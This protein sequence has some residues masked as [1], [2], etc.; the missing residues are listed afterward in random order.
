M[1]DAPRL[2]FGPP[3]MKKPKPD[4]LIATAG[5]DP[6]ANHG[7]IN[8]P[9]YHASTVV[10][11][12]VAALHASQKQRDPKKTR[13]GRYG[14]PTTFA[15]EEA[16]AALDGGYQTITVGSGV[17]A[18][19][20]VL[21]AFVQS[22]DHILVAD[23]VYGPTRRIADSLRRFGIATTYYDPLVGGGIAKLIQP[24]TRLIFMEAPGS[25]TFEMQDVPAI[26]AAARAANVKTAIDNTWATPLYFR[27][28]Q[29][30]VDVTLLSATKYIGGH[31]DLMMGLITTTEAAFPPVR[32]A[33][34][35]MGATAGPDDCYLALRGF[36]TLSVR[37]ERHQ[38]N[39]LQ[40]ARWLQQRPEVARVLHPG[41]PDDP[42]HALWRRDFTGASGLFGLEL[43]P[44]PESAVAAMLDDLE[45]FGMGYSWG[46]FESLILPTDPKPF[47]SAVAWSAPGPLLRIHAGL[48][49]P[50]DLI[51]DLDSGFT[52]LRDAAKRSGS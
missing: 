24:N 2:I 49:D 7:I 8:P 22:G 30:G 31:S 51:A 28:L 1:Q 36:R 14:T 38:K 34:D 39:A 27:P 17:A 46:G 29:H 26:V 3:P 52:R 42:G 23:T 10:F 5:R 35:D 47:R 32:R 18:I 19:S 25:L 45:L 6:E 44:V 48:E 13:Y 21:H 12:T 20:A 50:D 16:I 11:P 4:T 15:L 9:V 40:L 33:V 43:K 41:L 37:L